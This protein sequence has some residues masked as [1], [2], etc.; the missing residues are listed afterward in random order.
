MQN[1]TY[2]KN[3]VSYLIPVYNHDKYVELLLNSI[4]EDAKKLDSDKDIIIIDDGSTDNSNIVIQNW[5]DNQ[6]DFIKIKYITRENKGLTVTL[7][8]LISYSN[9]EYLRLCASDDILIPTSTNIML[10]TFKQNNNLLAV[11]GDAIIIDKNSNKIFDSSIK[12]H[13]GNIEKLINE[14]SSYNELI[15]HWCI[16]GPCS[17]IK[18]EF[19]EE[20]RYLENES[21][22]DFYLYLTLIKKNALK[23]ISDKLCYYR[24]HDTNTSKTTN[25]GK[26]IKNLNSFLKI[27]GR[28]EELESKYKTLLA[29]RNLTEAKIAY[30]ERNVFKCFLKLVN[31][32]YFRFL[33]K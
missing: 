10:Q 18:K 2:V 8:E 1:S 27:I 20:M 22:D 3:K 14:K 13:G 4:L 19:Y 16:A 31:Y 25:I 17:L 15:L 9:S 24:I 23:I 26:R 29:L 30:F 6:D 28:F 21:I 5:I 7:N 12:Y 33:N 32:T 11:C